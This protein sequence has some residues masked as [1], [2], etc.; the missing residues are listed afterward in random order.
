[1]VEWMKIQMVRQMDEW[2]ERQITDSQITD[3]QT[4]NRQTVR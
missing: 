1:M 3:R 4:D 2:R